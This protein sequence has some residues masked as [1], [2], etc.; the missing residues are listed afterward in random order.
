MSNI[1][2]LFVRGGHRILKIIYIHEGTTKYLQRIIQD[3]R[4]TVPKCDKRSERSQNQE[5][6]LYLPVPINLIAAK[7]LFSEP[8][9][10][11]G[12]NKVGTNSIC[13]P[14]APVIGIQFTTDKV[15]ECSR[16]GSS[17]NNNSLLRFFPDDAFSWDRVQLLECNSRL[18][19]WKQELFPTTVCTTGTKKN[20]EVLKKS[21]ERGGPEIYHAESRQSQLD[22]TGYREIRGVDGRS[23]RKKERSWPNIQRI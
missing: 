17:P 11:S 12:D 14:D 5:G 15:I 23:Q 16:E 8:L 22:T 19:N 2:V 7:Q 6:A 20:G 9:R 4:R 10:S 3:E 13:R 18:T 21:A 1:H